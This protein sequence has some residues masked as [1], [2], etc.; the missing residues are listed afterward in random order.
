M[1]QVPPYDDQVLIDK[2]ASYVCHNGGENRKIG[3]IT[4]K[5]G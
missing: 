1:V 2:T 4:Q 3:N 5:N